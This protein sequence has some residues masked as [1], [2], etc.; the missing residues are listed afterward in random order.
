MK[1]GEFY[2]KIA[3]MVEQVEVEKE[4]AAMFMIGGGKG[5]EWGAIR[6][7]GKNLLCL[8]VSQMETHKEI[9]ALI[10]TAAEIFIEMEEDKTNEKGQQQKLS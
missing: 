8:L 9:A 2:D 1:I 4:D 3:P 6:G 10:T 5:S 7:K